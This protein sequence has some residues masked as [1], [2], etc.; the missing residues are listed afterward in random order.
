MPVAPYATVDTRAG[1]RARDRSLGAP[2][3]LKTRRLGYD[4]KGQS[5]IRGARERATRWRAS[6][7][8]R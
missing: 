4:G 6:A 2:G 8:S 1:P 7:G 3:I 5:R